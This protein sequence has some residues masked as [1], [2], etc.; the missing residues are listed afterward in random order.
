MLVFAQ[1]LDRPAP[2]KQQSSST[3]SIS[4]NSSGSRGSGKVIMVVNKNCGQWVHVSTVCPP[5]EQP[6]Q[7]HAMAAEPDDVP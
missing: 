2:P 3:K 4:S 6:E 7:I 5:L 1:G